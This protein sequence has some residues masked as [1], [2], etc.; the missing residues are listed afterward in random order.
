MNTETNAPKKAIIIGAS[1]GIGAE[2]ARQLSN[3]GYMLGLTARR[4]DKIRKELQPDLNT[5]SFVSQMDVAETE[6]AIRCLRRLVKKMDGVDVIVVNAGISGKAARNPWTTAE[7]I[8]RINVLGFTAML[9]EAYRI[10]QKQ[11]YGHIAGVSSVAGLI[12]H[13][14][15]SAYN[16]SKAFESVYLDSLRNRIRRRG[17]PI[18]VTDIMPGYVHTPM[19]SENRRIFWTATAEKAVRQIICDLEK[20]KPIS[21]VSRRWRMIVWL[22]KLSPRR[23]VQLFNR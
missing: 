5:P 20:K 11:G 6:S 3:K 21:Y 15:A 13:A 23:L 7:E 18:T 9:L 1:S 19:T 17:E 16:A 2:L 22:L 8:I 12:P 14:N 4:A 10:F